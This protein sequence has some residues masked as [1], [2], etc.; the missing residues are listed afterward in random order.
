MRKD[1]VNVFSEGLNYDL[2]PITTPNNVLTDCVNGTFLTFNGDELALQNDAGNTKISYQ[3]SE[4][5]ADVFWT[6]DQA[7]AIEVDFNWVNLQVNHNEITGFVTYTENTFQFLYVSVPQN[8]ILTLY[9][10]LNYVLYDST[11]EDSAPTQLF[12]LIGTMTTPYGVINDVY[13][14]KDQFNT[15]NPILF[16]IKVFL[17]GVEDGELQTEYVQLSEGFKPLGMKEEGG[18]LYIIS[19]KK[20]EDNSVKWT[21]GKTYYKGQIVYNDT[22]VKTYYESLT[23]VNGAPLPLESNESWYIIGTVEDFNNRYGFV[24]LG[25]YP[26]PEFG[27]TTG[28]DGKNIIYTETPDNM[29]INQELYN[30]RTINNEF[31]KTGRYVSFIGTELN[32][33]TGTENISRYTVSGQNQVWDPKFY[34]I[35]LYHQLNNGY[36]D[37]TDDIW[38]KYKTHVGVTLQDLFWFEP[39]PTFMYYCPN[40][41]K[42]KLAMSIEIQEIETFQ[43]YGI[44]TIRFVD[45][46]DPTPDTFTLEI[47]VEAV[48]NA[49]IDI[50]NVI[51]TTTIEGNAPVTHAVTPVVSEAGTYIATFILENI[52]ITNQDKIIEYEIIPE[53]SYDG[54]V[55][56]SFLPKQYTDKYIITGK[57]VISSEYDFK[58]IDVETECD[59]VN[60]VKT[61]NVVRLADINGANIDVYLASSASQYVYLR[62]GEV[63]PVGAIKI[64][65]YTVGSTGYPVIAVSPAPIAGS[66]TVN[67]FFTTYKVQQYSDDCSGATFTASFNMDM[68]LCSLTYI[69]V[70]QKGVTTTITPAILDGQAKPLN[71]V[72]FT[73]I[74]N[75]QVIVE[76]FRAGFEVINDSFYP[77]GDVSRK[78]AFIANVVPKYELSGISGTP[79]AHYLFWE[80]ERGTIQGS[81]NYLYYKNGETPNGYVS[82]AMAKE[83]PAGYC[84]YI[85]AKRNVTNNV[86]VTGDT[87]TIENPD[88]LTEAY[89]NIP[90]NIYYGSK[91]AR[92]YSCGVDCLDDPGV[93]YTDVDIIFRRSID[94]RLMLGS[95]PEGLFI[96]VY[97]HYMPISIYSTGGLSGAVIINSDEYYTTGQEYS[98]THGPIIA[99]T[100]HINTDTL[101]YNYE[102]NVLDS[103]KSYKID[104]GL[105]YVGTSFDVEVVSASVTVDI[106]IEPNNI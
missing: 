18:V 83:K 101:L 53:F 34:I 10:E 94:P 33:A 95:V 27:G 50:N 64:A 59:Y 98:I 103:L 2:N 75:Y 90:N 20:P 77:S 86:F 60:Y 38:E 19:G 87:M 61:S 36:L 73:I 63:L 21:E 40:Q 43:L 31:F 6:L 47:K 30:F 42:G 66:S 74:P 99:G 57:R 105:I 5:Q 78:Y 4:V 71:D 9:N 7:E 80:A 89:V 15:N 65:E 26:S 29:T 17:Q 35:K 67:S 12:Y 45:Q 46:T 54:G 25:S 37:L 72:E 96:Y 3:Y 39:D 82:L 76:I 55:I 41:Y 79:Y 16:K 69:K 85:S 104:S 88:L 102:G 23:D 11:V 62:V 97:V 13:R 14:K 56:N 93:G 32:G 52:A 49:V 91:P 24:E 81:F 70:T 51:V 106:Y 22:L 84:N 1:S 58:F 100:Y 28:I 44:P 8:S 48:G 92:M 68:D